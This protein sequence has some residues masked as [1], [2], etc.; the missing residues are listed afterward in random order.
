LRPQNL[1]RSCEGTLIVLSVTRQLFYNAM[2]S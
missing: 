1:S 2:S